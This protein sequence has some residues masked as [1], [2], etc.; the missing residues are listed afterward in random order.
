MKRKIIQISKNTFVVSL[1]TKW[2]KDEKLTKGDELE[3]NI[4]NK[5][6]ICTPP[7]AN[8]DIKQIS[9]NIKEMSDQVL[10]WALTA[11][12]KKGW[13]EITLI[14]YSEKHV[15]I[16]DELL[17]NLFIGFIIKEKRSKHLTIGEIGKVDIKEF[18]PS[19]RRAFRLLN[20][21]IDETIKAFEKKD[22][23]YL[24]EQIIHERN[25]NQLTNFCERILNNNLTKKEN[26]HF[27]YVLAWNLEKISDNFKYISEY[28]QG[29][30]ITISDETINIMKT[31][32]EF[33]K[34]YYHL[35]YN[36]SFKELNKLIKNKESIEKEIF[37]QM[38]S[39]DLKHETIL[40]HFL[41]NTLFQMMDFTSTLIALK[42]EGE[43]SPYV[44]K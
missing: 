33:I 32:K 1:P 20:V 18:D 25:N 11:I 35:I 43:E 10:R 42:F 21:Q 8:N 23:S 15:K 28:F 27:W 34:D 12:Q 3:V 24:Q 4:K 38:I 30:I 40:L 17:N 44:I 6:L 2:L 41:H 39:E 9:L 22:N 26:G 31:L 14:N 16:I 7:N 13:D 36:F 29:A 37:K 19:L 5:E